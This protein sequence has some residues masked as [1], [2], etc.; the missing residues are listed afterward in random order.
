VN[1]SSCFRHTILS[2]FVKHGICRHAGG[3]ITGLITTGAARAR[4][5]SA[6]DDVLPCASQPYNKNLCRWRW[7]RLDASA[8][9]ARKFGE[10]E[11]SG[12][13]EG[14]SLNSAL[15]LIT[16]PV[17]N[18]GR[19]AL[20]N[21]WSKLRSFRRPAAPIAFWVH[22]RRELPWCW[23]PTVSPALRQRL[24]A[25]QVHY[26]IQSKKHLRRRSLDE[27]HSRQPSIWALVTASIEP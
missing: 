14:A 13:R 4:A 1:C 11:G 23:K 10:V 19:E 5:L 18:H 2:V 6:R 7:M 16:I 21:P 17:E 26:L 8:P 9:N 24:G 12:A 27:G 25:A 22:A 3:P 15:K 20:P